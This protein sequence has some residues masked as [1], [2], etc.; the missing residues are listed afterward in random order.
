MSD[1]GSA[2]HE[3]VVRRTR[4]NSPPN[5]PVGASGEGLLARGSTALQGVEG[6]AGAKNN[7]VVYIPVLPLESK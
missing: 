6:M 5:L 7:G 4:P 3:S 2:H 1:G